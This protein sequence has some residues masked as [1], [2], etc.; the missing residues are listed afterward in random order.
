MKLSWIKSC[1]A[2]RIK[3]IPQNVGSKTPRTLPSS[4]PT[5]FH[6]TV[7]LTHCAWYSFL[8]TCQLSS[9]YRPRRPGLCLDGTFLERALKPSPTEPL[10]SSLSCSPIL[11][12]PVCHLIFFLFA[13]CLSSFKS[14]AYRSRDLVQ[15]TS[16]AH[17]QNGFW[18]RTGSRCTV[19]EWMDEWMHT[20]MATW[21]KGMAGDAW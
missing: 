19:V 20:S 15:C 16:S 10:T 6:I 21:V 18:L 2:F 8:G 1:A 11:I 9:S 12:L 4:S 17:M 7:L 14:K 13:S 3:S 5:L